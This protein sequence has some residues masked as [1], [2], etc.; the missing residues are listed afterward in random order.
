MVE[1]VEDLKKQTIWLGY[2]MFVY[3]GPYI[4]IIGFLIWGTSMIF[5]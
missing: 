4:L 2:K 1:W 3:L 5:G